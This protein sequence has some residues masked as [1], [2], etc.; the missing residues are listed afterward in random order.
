MNKPIVAG[1][2]VMT[3]IILA[4]VGGWYLANSPGAGTGTPEPI[5]IGMEPNQVNSLIII[6]DDQGFFPAAGLNVTIKGY[7]SGAAAVN[8]MLAGEAD[9]AMA[10]EFVAVV[11]ALVH[12]RICTFATIDKFQQI[13]LVGRKDRGIENTSDMKGKNIG[14]TKKT[15]AEFYLGRYLN[16]HGMHMQDVTLVDIMPAQLAEGLANGTVDAVVTWQPYV[17]TIEGRM[18]NDTIKWPAQS[19]Q[20]AYCSAISTDNWAAIHPETINKLLIALARAEDY[21]INHPDEAK[22]IVQ[23]RLQYED[24]YISTIWPEHQFSLSL[25]QSLVTAMEDEGR[26]MI[27]NNLT[28]ETAIPDFRKY[29]YTN[30]LEVVRPESVNI[31]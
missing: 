19:M 20:V 8:G 6:A 1:I 5:T 7:P 23:K 29:V 9:I 27:A 2:A 30:G 12:E 21:T 4:I 10:T 18:G 14:V 17:R 25:D 24:A 16:L 28:N 31:W 3:M 15:A 13:Y 26:W 22:A 11:K